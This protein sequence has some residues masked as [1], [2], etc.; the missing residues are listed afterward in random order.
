MERLTQRRGS[1]TKHVMALEERYHICDSQGHA[2]PDQKEKICDYCYRRLN[3]AEIHSERNLQEK[4]DLALGVLMIK[5]E[6]DLF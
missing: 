3:Y 4:I 1:V 2:N 5:R 6:E